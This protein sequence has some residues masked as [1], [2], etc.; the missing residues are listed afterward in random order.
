MTVYTFTEARQQLAAVLDQA[1]KEGAVQIRRRDGTT[2]R[3]NGRDAAMR[4]NTALGH[5]TG[6]DC[7][8]ASY[9]AETSAS[10]SSR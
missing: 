4:R 7:M 2:Y 8:A 3:A 10:A 9:S 1:L 5:R 6:N